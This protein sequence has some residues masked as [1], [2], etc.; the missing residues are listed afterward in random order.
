MCINY[1]VHTETNYVRI[2][3]NIYL[4]KLYPEPRDTLILRILSETKLSLLYSEKRKKQI[5][6]APYLNVSLLKRELYSN[7]NVKRSVISFIYL[8][9]NMLIKLE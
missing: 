1:L 6:S 9:Y 4:I 7:T 8:F 5:E 3:E 2:N